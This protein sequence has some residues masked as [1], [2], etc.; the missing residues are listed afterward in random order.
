MNA[1]HA[2]EHGAPVSDRPATTRTLGAAG[3]GGAVLFTVG[4]LVQQFYRRGTYDP[5]AQLISDLTA[6]PYGW[7]QQVNF[8]VFGLLVI[9]FAAGLQRGVRP[10]RAR[11]VGPAIIGF[12]GLGLVVAGL[13]PL[14]EDAAGLVYDP[15]GVHTVNGV[16]FFL[17]I[18][19]VLVV[20][21]LR[22]RADPTWRGLATYT[23][24]TGIALVVLFVIVVALARLT[25]A[26]LHDWFGLVQ[27]L[28]LIVWLACIVVLALRLRRVATRR[29]GNSREFGEGA[30]AI[31]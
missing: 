3:I 9:T 13:F 8:V 20:V 25:D 23:L 18:G 14:R 1:T 27:R 19:I 30:G 17:S 2:N 16:I 26:P 6:G 12:N 28:V 7:V 11:V 29:D 10:P 5:I 22:L 21:S 24:A 4:I 15:I 31:A